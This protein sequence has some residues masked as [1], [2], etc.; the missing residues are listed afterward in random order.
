MGG[1]G[2][3]MLAVVFLAGWTRGR[4][5][6]LGR[7]SKRRSDQRRLSKAPAARIQSPR[8]QSPEGTREC[9]QGAATITR[10]SSQGLDHLLL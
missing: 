3:A 4:A 5:G 7:G 10:H 1:V 6:S 2:A 8:V 9:C